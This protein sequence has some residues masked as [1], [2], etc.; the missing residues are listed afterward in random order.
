M[1][2][3]IRGSPTVTES[4]G[5]RRTPLLARAWKAKLACTFGVLAYYLVGYF[6]LNRFPFEHYHDVPQVSLL[7]DLP[8]IP[9][10]IIVYNSVFV[11]G[12]LAI[13]LLPDAKT[14]KVYFLSVLISYT[15]NYLFFAVYPTR[16]QRSPIPAGDS[17]WLLGL[18]I[19]RH[20]DDPYTCFPS[21]HITNCTLGVLALWKTRYGKWFLLWTV[22]IALSTLTVDQHLFLDLPAGAAVAIMGTWMARRLL[23][24]LKSGENGGQ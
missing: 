23:P 12:A 24:V 20:L 10:T 17:L 18:R 15:I 5:D 14:V 11:L 9:W 3:F 13:W 4:K 8:I 19:T 2:S 7:D 16:I 6:V 22:T 1:L 21:L